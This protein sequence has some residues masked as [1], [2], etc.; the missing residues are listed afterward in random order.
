VTLAAF[1]TEDT[2]KVCGLCGGYSYNKK[3]FFM[4][5]TTSGQ[6][7]VKRRDVQAVFPQ[8]SGIKGTLIA[9]VPKDGQAMGRHASTAMA[10]TFPYHLI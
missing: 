10:Q 1:F 8:G 9:L 3:D 7:S 4:L 5:G 6:R 2:F